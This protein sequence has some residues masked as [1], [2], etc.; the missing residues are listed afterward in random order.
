MAVVGCSCCEER[1]EGPKEAAEA[2]LLGSLS[3]LAG[4]WWMDGWQVLPFA[5][6]EAE[7]LEQ[8]RT[9]ILG[10]GR[11]CSRRRRRGPRSVGTTK[12]SRSAWLRNEFR[13]SFLRSARKQRLWPDVRRLGRAPLGL[14][15]CSSCLS[16]STVIE[17]DD[18]G[19]VAG[20][21]R[22]GGAA[23]LLWAWK[24]CKACQ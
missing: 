14:G 7:Q 2:V 19:R 3:R 20:A 13:A 23:E 22:R 17:S 8:G 16:W 18:D 12:T 1:S 11:S 6:R 24:R 15:P 9:P 4:P 21:E 10:A 5:G